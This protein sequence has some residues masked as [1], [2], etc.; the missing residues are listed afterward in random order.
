MGPEAKLEA[1]FKK[2]VAIAGGRS[3][4][5]V[6]PS[7][8]GATDQIVMVP[9]GVTVYVEIK[10]GNKDLSPLQKIFQR[11]SIAMR[12]RHEVIRFETDIPIFIDKY[13][14]HLL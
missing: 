5:F 4:K 7:N 8:R 12:Q 3:Y 13:F 2:A 1:K 10:N 9:D 6:S 14:W 11:D